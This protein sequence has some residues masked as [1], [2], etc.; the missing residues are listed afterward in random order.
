MFGL[1]ARVPPG[2][3][4]R[5]ALG[6]IHLFHVGARGLACHIRT[7]THT[8]ARVHMRASWLCLQS[9]SFFLVLA[10]FVFLTLFR[11]PPR[12]THLAVRLSASD[13]PSSCPLLFP[14]F[15]SR[16]AR[17]SLALLSSFLEP[18][19]APLRRATRFGSCSRLPSL[20]LRSIAVASCLFFR[21]AL[22]RALAPIRICCALSPA[23]RMH[24]PPLPARARAPFSSAPT[25]RLFV[26]PNLIALLLGDSSFSVSS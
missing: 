3:L 22:A 11:F 12:P 17:P 7:H 25:S 10:S 16:A 20:M 14:R 2:S 4:C 21:L 19:H 23:P 6:P 18:A 9:R 5:F 8:H 15:W 1:F 24:H 26:P 13:G